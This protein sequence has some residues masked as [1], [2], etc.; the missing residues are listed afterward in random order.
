LVSIQGAGRTERNS[1]PDS[2]PRQIF[3]DRGR[4]LVD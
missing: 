3:L 1:I 4:V 2:K